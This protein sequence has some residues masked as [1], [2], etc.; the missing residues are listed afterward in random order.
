VENIFHCLK[1]TQVL[2]EQYD[3]LLN[4]R[5][6]IFAVCIDKDKEAWLKK[7][8][9]N[10]LSWI[11]CYDPMETSNYRDKYY[12]YGSP[13]LFVIGQNKKILAIKN[14]ENEIEEFVNQII[15]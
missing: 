9:E 11:N 5:I 8:E 10:E 6:R 13:I 4:K 15:R 2:K 14:G 12:V 7:I 1:S 3:A